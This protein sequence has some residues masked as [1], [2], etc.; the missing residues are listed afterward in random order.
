[1]LNFPI[2]LDFPLQQFFRRLALGC[3]PVAET[4][5]SIAQLDRS[6]KVQ[7]FFRFGTVRQQAHNVTRARVR[8]QDLCVWTAKYF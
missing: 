5:Q 7:E 4:R 8:I 3:V 6:F 2:A 1:M